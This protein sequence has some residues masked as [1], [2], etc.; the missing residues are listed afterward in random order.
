MNKIDEIKSLISEL[1][2]ASIAYHRDDNPIMSD[3]EYDEKYNKLESLE[4][5]TAII[6]ANSP[7][8]KVQGMILESLQKITHTQS[9]LSADKTKSTNDIIKFGKGKELISSWKEDGLTLVLRF[10]NGNFNMAITRGDGEEGEIVTESAKTI[11]NLPLTIPYLDELELR[12]ECVMT[13]EDFNIIKDSLFAEGKECGHP[14]NVAG[15]ALRQLDIS[16]VR[17]RTLYFKAFDITKC[18]KQFKTKKEQ[19]EFLTSL[20]F[21]T[22][23][24]QLVTTPEEIQDVVNNVF[25]PEQYKFP[26][27]GIIFE[28]NDIEYG[29]SLGQTAKFPLSIMAFKWK[30]DTTQT[31]FRGIEFNPTRT[32]LVSMTA[33]YDEVRVENTRISRAT[34][35]NVD[36][37]EKYQFGLGDSI[38]VYKANKIIPQVYENLT[39]SNTYKILE[40]CPCC[41]AKLEIKKPK[42]SKFLYCPNKEC[43]VKLVKKFTHFTSKIGFNIDGLSESTLEKFIDKGWIKTFSDIFHLEDYK[44]EIITMEGFGKKSYDNLIKAIEDSKNIK[45]SNFITALGIPNVGKTASKTISEYFNGNWNDFENAYIDNFDFTKLDDIGQII[46]DSL[47]KY[48]SKGEMGWFDLIDEVTFIKPNK[49]VEVIVTDN[50]LNGK[51]VYATGTFANFKKTELQTIIEGLGATFSSGYAK[52]LDYLIVGSLKGSG[53]EDKARADGVKIMSEEEFCN[54]IK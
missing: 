15:G 40:N 31:T 6:F 20:G 23:E 28:F 46:N 33:L 29:K 25:I 7:T 27:D 12:G 2:L 36:Y 21:E 53:K 3:K 52:S 45:L 22:V 30:D 38:T 51:K 13:W 37:F 17:E 26:V 34:I 39:M 43:P 5:E 4:K 49:P 32:G 35:P 41:N 54:L 48:L 24:Y 19:F 14:R 1:T 8:Q 47:Y 10:K 50:L 18:T 9:M 11:V 16:K 42:D 44:T